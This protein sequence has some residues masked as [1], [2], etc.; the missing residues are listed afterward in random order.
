MK[1]RNTG[2]DLLRILMA[3]AVVGVHCFVR[4][5]TRAGMFAVPVFMM[6]AFFYASG[7]L[8]EGNVRWLGARL[9]R[10]YL[11][12][13]VWAIVALVADRFLLGGAAAK[14]V[15]GGDSQWRTFFIH[16][17]GGT[18]LANNMQMWFIGNLVWLTPAFFLLLR[19]FRGK[20]PYWTVAAVGLL[21][22]MAQ[23]SGLNYRWWSQVSEFGIRIP[24]GR[25]LEMVPCCCIGLLAGVFKDRF[26]AF[27]TGLRLK[28][29]FFS[30]GLFVFLS[31]YNVF[32]ACNGFA[33]QGLY[34]L[35]LALTAIGI[36][37]FLPF[38]LLPD[39]VKRT[40]GVV[41]AYSMGVYMT[42]VVLAR[43]CEKYVFGSIG[44]A[45][46]TLVETLAVFAVSWCLCFILARI[47]MCRR[48]VI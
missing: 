37:L 35:A 28:I 31:F 23:Y 32:A 30:L 47:P 12:F 24:G 39:F 4:D 22:L 15:Y 48:L 46:G 14:D 21:A 16:L 42:H 29:A 26:G 43:L 11:P 34:R 33:Y 9:V 41:A 10:L 18:A 5:Y 7:R 13:L 40:I 20:M 44:V 1:Q 36:F 45:S 8:A 17:V 3:L 19:P 25:L 27:S 2:V 6:L 38:E